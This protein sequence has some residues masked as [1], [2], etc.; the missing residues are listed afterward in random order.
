VR[1][2]AAALALLAAASMLTTA[3][4]G[5]STAAPR[6]IN[7]AGDQVPVAPLVDAEAGLCAARASA[8]TDP[9]AARAAFYNRSHT[10]LHTVARALEDVDRAEAATLL[11]AKQKVESGLDNPP[12]T[13]PADLAHLADVYRAGLG[14]LAISAPPCEK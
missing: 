11:E 10:S 12:P 3:C 7:V 4:G 14:R 13:L 8:A 5:S 1:R 6:T 2:V 9:V